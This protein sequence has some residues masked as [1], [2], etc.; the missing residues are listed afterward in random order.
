MVEQIVQERKLS[1]VAGAAAIVSALLLVIS[2]KTPDSLSAG[3]TVA[4][5]VL[6]LPGAL[7]LWRWLRPRSTVLV[8]AASGA[9]VAAILL[10]T[11][12]TLAGWGPLEPVWVGLE[13]VWWLGI[14][15]ALRPAWKWLGWATLALGIAAALNLATLL[16]ALH[17]PLWGLGEAGAGW[18]FLGALRLPML[19]VWIGWL[20]ALLITRPEGERQRHLTPAND[21]RGS[22]KA[23]RAQ[24][25]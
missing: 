8:D 1:L 21:A 4:W 22:A 14:G 13:V 18:F 6:L 23:Q 9:G 16:A 2:L 19:V 17:S 7:R 24:R 20:G 15:W 25:E 12:A 5:T 11:A 10:R 3:L